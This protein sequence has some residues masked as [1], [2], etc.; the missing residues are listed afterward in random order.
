MAACE[1]EEEQQ[2][3]WISTITEMM[4]EGPMMILR[5]SKIR[6]SLIAHPE[7]F[8]WYN[9]RRMELEM[10]ILMLM[11]SS[12]LFTDENGVVDWSGP[13][14]QTLKRRKDEIV[15]EVC[16]RMIMKGSRVNNAQEV[17]KR[18]LM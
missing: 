1:L 14:L 10:L 7:P 16:L 6:Q 3:K 9:K 2:R 5:L 11:N 8:R 18:M 12:F 13:I 4:N 15:T 17:L